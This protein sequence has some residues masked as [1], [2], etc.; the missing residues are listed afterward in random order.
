[1]VYLVVL[2]GTGADVTVAR[3]LQPDPYPE[4]L[5]KARSSLGLERF[6]AQRGF[7]EPFIWLPW[8][9]ASVLYRLSK[10]A[11]D[12]STTTFLS[13]IPWAMP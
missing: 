5:L 13:T 7:G 12:N 4:N 3:S 11:E 2:Y 8:V 6:H 9:T 1:M 10:K